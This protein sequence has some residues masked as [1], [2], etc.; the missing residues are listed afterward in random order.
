M[1]KRDFIASL[2]NGWSRCLLFL[3]SNRIK[4]FSETQEASWKR[5]FR[6]GGDMPITSKSEDTLF[7][8]PFKGNYRE[9]RESLS[10]VAGR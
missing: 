3:G 7:S 5:M 6:K 10:G 2:S 9:R 8:L 4:I 1:D